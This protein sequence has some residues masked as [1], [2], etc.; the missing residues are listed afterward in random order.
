MNHLNNDH[1]QPDLEEFNTLNDF[2][3]N[4]TLLI[5]SHSAAAYTKALQAVRDQ[6]HIAWIESLPH[7]ARRIV[8]DGTTIALD[9]EREPDKPGTV[10]KPGIRRVQTTT[11]RK[12]RWGGR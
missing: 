4:I 12:K 5:P 2:D 7:D 1:F 3:D 9:R 10:R 8:L 6:V 11:V